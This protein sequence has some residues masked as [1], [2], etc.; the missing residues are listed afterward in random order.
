MKVTLIPWILNAVD[1]EA[2]PE[3]IIPMGILS[4]SAVL[5]QHGHE[6]CIRDYNL[7]GNLRC[8]IGQF[9]RQLWRDGSRVYG[10]STAA[11]LL[12]TPLRL[13]EA[14]K[15]VMPEAVVV[16]GGPHATVADEDIIGHFDCVDFVARN[17]G[18]SVLLSLI[19]ALEGKTSIEEV[20]GITFRKDGNIIRSPDAAF[21]RDLD[22]LPVP[23]YASYPVD[24]MLNTFI[25]VEVGRGC[26]FRCAFCS[27]SEIWGRLY[28]VKSVER[29]IAEIKHLKASYNANRFYFRHDQIIKNRRW[30]FRLCDGLSSELPGIE[31]Q[32]SARIDSI[33]ETILGKMKA[34]GCTGVELG[35]ESG[36]KKIQHDIGKELSVDDIMTGVQLVNRQ[37][38]EA[39]L[40]FMCGFPDEDKQDV[41]D[42]MNLIMKSS[43]VSK[44]GAFIQNRAL[45]PFPRTPAAAGASLEFVEERVPPHV[46][47]TY[48][49]DQLALARRSPSL[50]PE[51]YFARNREGISPGY[52]LQ[53]ERFTNHVIQFYRLNFPY[54][55]K[56]LVKTVDFDFQR[57]SNLWDTVVSRRRS[58]GEL[59]EEDMLEVTGAVV[60]Y[61]AGHYPAVPGWVRELAGYEGTIYELRR[62]FN[63]APVDVSG[64]DIAH[65]ELRLSDNA[66]IGT[67]NY[68][69]PAI[70]AHIKND[71][72][73]PGN[74]DFSSPG[75]HIMFFSTSI[76][77]VMTFKIDAKAAALL[78][79]LK[80]GRK[81]SDIVSREG[82]DA[83][84]EKGFKKMVANLM[85][86]GM[87]IYGTGPAY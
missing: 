64:G 2:N 36:S 4:I 27:A 1:R 48:T 34:A 39:I 45:I 49:A 75:T 30:L 82:L 14:L 24:S 62:N 41:Y 50:F 5:K 8:D 73:D 61:L 13:A 21:I 80:E 35:I 60:E 74:A 51:F 53:L 12:H 77:N 54:F 29:I 85:E 55:F 44:G 33:D 3:R 7:P 84:A 11:G 23:D 81:L 25:P 79:L 43:F 20:K 58:P 42:T 19:D 87:V 68:N 9:A 83:G 17:E 47:Q 37:G 16:F 26:P 22:R 71:F 69:I 28:R 6:V 63:Q 52:F 86:K 15:D 10:F 46:R 65:A 78:S 38:M 70:M 31:W 59:K 32:C 66:D 67:F 18:E 57:F 72:N 40:F 56:W 76:T